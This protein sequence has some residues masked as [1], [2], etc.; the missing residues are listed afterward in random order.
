MKGDVRKVL[1]GTLNL[2]GG[3]LFELNKLRLPK[4]LKDK[5]KNE[6]VAYVKNGIA[7]MLNNNRGE[8]YDIVVCQEMPYDDK[9]F[10]Q[11]QEELKLI[12]Y[13]IYPERDYF[14]YAQCISTFIVKSDLS[15]KSIDLEIGDNYKNKFSKILV[16]DDI[17]I[18][19]VHSPIDRDACVQ[20]VNNLNT[21]NKIILLGDFN[22]AKEKQVIY[23]SKRDD[24]IN[25]ENNSFIETIE[26]KHDGIKKFYEIGTDDQHTYI[27]TNVR[28]KIDHVFFSQ[29]LYKDLNDTK[30]ILNKNVNFYEEPENGFT[31]HSMLEFNIDL[32][33]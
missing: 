31:D 19:N 25:V 11:I 21:N 2:H 28:N 5:Y 7:S 8:I 18:V 20:I 16:R 29:G 33:Y 32:K 14:K 15:C 6:Y 4:T 12:G 22:A 1:I 24:E 26:G 10:L 17:E 30:V 13:K 27:T 23:P 3:I 9:Y